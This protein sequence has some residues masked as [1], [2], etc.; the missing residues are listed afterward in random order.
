M[1]IDVSGDVQAAWA[2]IFPDHN[3]DSPWQP[4][5]FEEQ[6]GFLVIQCA[7]N[8]WKTQLRLLA[9]ALLA[10]LNAALTSPRI[11][12]IVATIREVRV[13][14]TGSRSWT[15]EQAIANALLDAWHDAVQAIS[16]DVRFVIVHGDCPAGADRIAKDWATAN[17]R[18][19]EP[20]PADWSA[21]CAEA[22]PS[23]PHRKTSSRHG[24]YCPLAGHRRNQFMVDLGADLLLAFRRNNSRGTTDCIN[25]AKRAGIPTLTFE[26]HCD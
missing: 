26:E 18:F 2:S 10:K 8:T 23:T 16:P 21:P 12:K 20:H 24:D 11:K 13:L 9:P 4:S 15:D 25:R 14:V 3:E 7:N 5:W 22:C 6:Q 1:K 19:H 17:G